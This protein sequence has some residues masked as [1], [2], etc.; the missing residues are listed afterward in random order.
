M[1][2]R[3]VVPSSQG[4]EPIKPTEAAARL[5]ISRQ[6]IHQLIRTGRLKATPQLGVIGYDIDPESVEE[7]HRTQKEVGR[8]KAA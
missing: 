7:Y 8:P 2:T 5:G 3:G 1:S 4:G 6:A